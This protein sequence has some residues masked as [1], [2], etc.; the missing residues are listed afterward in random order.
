[1][2]AAGHG[3]TPIA[4]SFLGRIKPG[5]VLT[6]ESIDVDLMLPDFVIED[7][8]RRTEK[9]CRL[10]A[11]AASSLQCVLDEIFLIGGNRIK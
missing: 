11:V 1:M 10:G 3:S 4:A 5:T 2:R 7:A 8:L 9:P 6:T